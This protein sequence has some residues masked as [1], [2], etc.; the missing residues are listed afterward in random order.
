MFFVKHSMLAHLKR[1]EVYRRITAL[2]DQRRPVQRAFP[3]IMRS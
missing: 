2:G 3:Y 1:T